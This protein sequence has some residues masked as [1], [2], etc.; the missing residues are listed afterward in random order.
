MKSRKLF[1]RIL[2][3]LLAFLMISGFI[4][5][6]IPVKAVTQADLQALEEKRAALEAKLSD[7]EKL[8]KS[9]NENH[10]L[11]VERKTA[12]DQQIALNR[13]N[14]ALME[15]ELA[16]YDEL[17]TEK[18]A[19]LPVPRPP[20]RSRPPPSGS[21]SGPWRR[22]GTPACCTISSRRTAF[23]SSSPVWGT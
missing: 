10:A 23:P 20:R 1:V 22:R 17:V 2:C 8:V 9:L 7:Q 3:V 13:E 12:L 11:I 16:A 19:E 15:A 18:E 6:V 14:I 21:G 4:M 5:M